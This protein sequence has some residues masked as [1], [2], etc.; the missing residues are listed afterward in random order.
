MAK[1]VKA[2][3][4]KAAYIPNM[5]DTPT[6]TEK[7]YKG[8][9]FVTAEQQQGYQEVLDRMKSDPVFGKLMIA[10]DWSKINAIATYLL[11]EKLNG[12]SR[13]ED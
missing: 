7:V 13:G 10:P 5:S 2:T 6:V 9:E 12:N 4:A 11:L 3:T 1:P 8:N